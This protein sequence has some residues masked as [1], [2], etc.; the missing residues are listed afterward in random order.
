MNDNFEINVLDKKQI[1]RERKR[2]NLIYFI[3]MQCKPCFTCIDMLDCGE[4]S[5]WFWPWTRICSPHFKLS[6]QREVGHSSA[7]RGAFAQS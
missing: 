7:V 4:I 1:E 5:S 6:L 2:E 3:S